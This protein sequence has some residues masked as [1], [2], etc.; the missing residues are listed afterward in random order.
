MKLVVFL[1]GDRGQ[2]L[3][4]AF[5]KKN[6]YPT[7]VV[8]PIGGIK[9]NLQE[10]LQKFSKVIIWSSDV[11]SKPI[12][13][14][15]KNLKPD[16]MIIAGYSQIFKEEILGI[17]K[18]GVLNLH[19]GPLPKYRGG[20]PL[21]WQIINGENQ[22][23]ISVITVDKGIDTGSVMAEKKFPL[24][25]NDT[26]KN[27]QDKANNFFPNLVFK[28]IKKIEEGL[29]GKAQSNRRAIYWHQRNDADGKIDFN[30]MTADQVLRRIRALSNPYPGAWA[31]Y[32]GK[33]IRLHAACDVNNPKIKGRAGRICFIQGVG[34]YVIC[35]DAAIL[36]QD[37]KQDGKKC[38][39]LNHGDCFE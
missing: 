39:G 26:I 12:I 10:I 30:L 13:R 5:Q 8:V 28:A 9:N 29:A 36:L 6:I 34:P 23:G 17:A 15:L 38:V 19:A 16:L 33:K 22:I 37:Y 31:L 24:C 32:N 20:S 7:A 27:I 11:N 25:V 4:E 18:H 2:I 14:K 21:N 3:L 1:N 35:K